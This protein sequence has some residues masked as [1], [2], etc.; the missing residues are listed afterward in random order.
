[1]SRTSRDHSV[2]RPVIHDLSAAHREEATVE[3]CAEDYAIGQAQRADAAARAQ[4]EQA[5]G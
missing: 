1:M 4:V 2:R 3:R 5:D